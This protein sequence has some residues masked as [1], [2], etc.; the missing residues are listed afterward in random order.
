MDLTSADIGRVL[1]REAPW[2]F[3]DSLSYFD[4]NYSE[5][6]DDDREIVTIVRDFFADHFRSPPVPRLRGIDVGAGTNLYPALTLLP[7]CSEIL[8]YERAPTNVAWLR[9]QI[10]HLGANWAPFWDVLCASDSYRDLG[11]P[12]AALHSTAVVKPG[13]LFELPSNQWEIGTMF[14]VAESMSNHRDEFEEAVARFLG[15]LVPDA[16][17]AIAFMENS[18]GYTVGDRDFPAYP[19]TETDVRRCLDKYAKHDVTRIAIPGKPVRD[20]YTG[21]LV[22]CGRRIGDLPA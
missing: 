7:W 11:N 17:F 20:G 18:L 6:R 19:V 16:P 1:N 9:G 5:L 2:D 8:L 13:D 21:M 10:D 3:F 22:A 15:A 4:H 12:A 14:F